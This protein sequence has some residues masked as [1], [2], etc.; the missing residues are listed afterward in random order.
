M[1]F[2]LTI[3]SFLFLLNYNTFGQNIIRHYST[4]DGLIS[5]NIYCSLSD[6]KGF[7]WFGTDRGVSKFDGARFENYTIDDGLTD[8]EVLKLFED[9]DGRIWFLTYNGVPCFYLNGEFFNPQKYPALAAFQHTTFFTHAHE[10]DAR[11]LFFFKEYSNE[12]FIITDTK[13]EKQITTDSS[14]FISFLKYENKNGFVTM[15]RLDNEKLAYNY[16]T[17]ENKSE[18]VYSQIT[19]NYYPK[20]ITTNNNSL[21]AVKR[22]SIS[23]NKYIWV[24]PESWNDLHSHS[25]TNSE[26]FNLFSLIDIIQIDDEIITITDNGLK[27]FSNDLKSS[28]TILSGKYTTS[29]TKDY[30]NGLWVTTRFDGIYQLSDKTNYTKIIAENALYQ[31]KKNP[32]HENEFWCIGDASVI[33][34]VGKDSITYYSTKK[35]LGNENPSDIA[36][37]RANELLIGSGKGLLFFKDGEFIELASKSGIK[38][39]WISNDSVY[40]ARSSELTVQ[41]YSQIFKQLD[42]KN[43]PYKLLHTGRTICLALRANNKLIAG[44]NQGIFEIDIVTSEKKRV[45]GISSRIKKILI[46]K[47]YSFYGSDVGGIYISDAKQIIHLDANSGLISNSVNSFTEGKEGELW[48]ATDKGL[49]KIDITNKTIRNYNEGD[50]LPDIRVNDIYYFGDDSLMLACPTGLYEFTPAKSISKSTPRLFIRNVKINNVYHDLNSVYELTHTE[51]NIE[52]EL[53]GVAFNDNLNYYYF[54]N[55]DSTNIQHLAGRTLNFVNLSHGEHF[56]EMRCKNKFGAWSNSIMLTFIIQPPFYE[57]TFFWVINLTVLFLIIL[58]ILYF[59]QARK[60]RKRQ[61]ELILSETRQKAM[62]A[63]LNPHFVFNA[64][65]SIQYL[66]M[67]RKEE[68]AH[69]YLSD[70]SILLRNILK[71]TDKSYISLNEELNNLKLYIELER[72]RKENN[73]DYELKINPEVD[74]YLLQIPVMMLQPFVENSLWHGLNSNNHNGKLKIEILRLQENKIEITIEDNGHGFE[75]EQ[76]EKINSKGI[77]LIKERIAAM[78]KI[79]PGL[80]SFN[81]TSN[82]NGTSVKFV[83]TEK[84]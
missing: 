35:I 36:F 28:A 30:T 52:I 47:N 32:F 66:F 18:P 80:I 74:I 6:K 11:E 57:T 51:N 9:S 64:L 56:V 49:S 5:N 27:L 40:I 44:D 2:A 84:F 69:S 33:K 55:S 59:T 34:L 75:P 8:N 79:T 39:I 48:V 50:G 82:S 46:T 23:E 20:I 19:S 1:R 67:S 37:L 4:F 21:L 63:Q 76:L 13:I 12:Y 65:N 53:S 45:E 10:T 41:S 78:N 54:L 83:F 38:Q 14:I 26:E 71:H 7:L 73:F 3:F 77:K 24:R 68:E 62:Q 17:F 16:W 58:L 81:I 29:V 15:K 31:I 42:Y 22:I 25:M 72:K 43:P 70:F 61:I 60:N